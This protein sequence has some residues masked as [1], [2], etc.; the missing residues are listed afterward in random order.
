[1]LHFYSKESHHN[2][3]SS[4]VKTECAWVVHEE[5]NETVNDDVAWTYGRVV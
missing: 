4:I 5:V 3:I 2:E 1:M